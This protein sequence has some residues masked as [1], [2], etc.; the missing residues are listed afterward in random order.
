MLSAPVFDKGRD[1]RC[2]AEPRS[3]I[4]KNGSA[5]ASPSRV[6]IRL[7][8]SAGEEGEGAVASALGQ[9]QGGSNDGLLEGEEGDGCDRRELGSGAVRPFQAAGDR[10]A[11]AEVA[12]GFHR[13]L[14]GFARGILAY[15]RDAPN[16]VVLPKIARP[17][18]APEPVSCPR[19]AESA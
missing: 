1:R 13:K 6:G 11:A 15:R 2:P 18:Q 19:V 17:E 14:A 5:G 10:Q 9:F 12:V 4:G 7:K 16:G 8:Q 3:I